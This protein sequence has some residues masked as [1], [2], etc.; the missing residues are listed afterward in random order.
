MEMHPRLIYCSITGYGQSGRRRDQAGH[1]L[2]YNAAAGVLGMTGNP[3]GGPVVPGP[4][5]ADMVGGGFQA[6]TAI[7]AALI[8]RGKTG[9]GC[10]LDIAMS[11]GLLALLV[12]AQARMAGG[13][14]EPGLGDDLLTGM[15]PNYRIYETADGHLAVG[16][17]EP[18]FWQR[19]LEA[20]GLQA[21]KD[22]PLMGPKAPATIDAVAAH[23]KTQSNEAWMERL[24]PADCCVEPVMGL[25]D[26]LANPDFIERD[27]WVNRPEGHSTLRLLTGLPMAPSAA[28]AA[29]A[30]NGD[31]EAL[32]KEFNP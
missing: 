6:L 22:A 19:F 18:V 3:V 21:L 9:E 11:E 32:E 24:G 10:T 1:D 14:G 5:I 23:L 27:R 12:L 17:L 8:Q 4:P 20:A 31:R 28:G 15:L 13:S 25:A 26:A 16:A 7:L 29:P 30:L 2:N